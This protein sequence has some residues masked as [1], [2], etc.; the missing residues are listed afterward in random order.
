VAKWPTLLEPVRP[1]TDL[2]RRPDDPRLWE[3][4]EFW[5]GDPA[6]LRPG[7]CVIVGFPQDEGVRRNG[8]RPGAAEAPQAI[9]AALWRFVPTD[10]N[11]GEDFSLSRNPPLDIG[12]IR[13]HGTLEDSQEA[14]GQVVAKILQANAVP[15]ILGGGHET[16]YGHFLGYVYANR[17]VGVI[18]FDAHLDVRPLID[19]HGHSGSPFR[20]M[21]EHPTHPLPGKRYVCLGV[22]PQATAAAHLRYVLDRGSFIETAIKMGGFQKQEEL[23]KQQLERFRK[24]RRSVLFSIDA[25]VVHEHDV[26]GVSAPN[27]AGL[28]GHDVLSAA[29]LAGACPYVTSFDLVEINPRFDRDGQSARWAAL[30]IWYFMTRRCG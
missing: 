29:C 10:L 19:G 5:N 21:M 9:R 3:V 12:D 4:I 17:K 18:N 22:Q 16:A 1:P 20:Q 25:D 30:A 15:V 26:P 27:P 6:A 28:S 23:L 11:L 7:R 8:G 2:I 24:A 13:I 14:L